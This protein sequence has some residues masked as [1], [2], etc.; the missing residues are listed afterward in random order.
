MPGP[1]TFQAI[2]ETYLTL[3]QASWANAK[4]RQQWENALN[5][6][7]YS[8][9]GDLP[10]GRINTDAVLDILTPFWTAKPETASRVRGRIETIINYGKACGWFHGENPTAW[11]FN[12]HPVRGSPRSS[13]K[14]A[15][16]W[17]RSGILSAP[18]P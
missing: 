17:R 12:R 2:A 3:R 7:V 1:R 14:A 4:H 15:T 11:R 8:S 9:L 5:T 16:P 18:C 10:I 13:I 6:Y